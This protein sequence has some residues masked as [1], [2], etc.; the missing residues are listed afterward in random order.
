MPESEISS[1]T[2]KMLEAGTSRGGVAGMEQNPSIVAAREYKEGKLGKLP[3]DARFMRMVEAGRDASGKKKPADVTRRDLVKLTA[4][5]SFSA[6]LALGGYGFGVRFMFPN[7]LNEPEKRIR[8]AELDKFREMP[9]GGVNN[10]WKNSG[11]WIIRDGGTIAALSTTCTH[12]GCIPSWLEADRKFKCPC[13]GSGFDQRGVNFE[14]P[15]PRPLERFKVIDEDGILVVDK[16]KKYQ[17]E[18]GEW[19]NPES[20]IVV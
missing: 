10:E 18:K 14:G 9:R 12:L 20:Y 13:H 16:S 4:W 5:G 7:V 1:A 6:A 3:P 2:R 19:N 8:V 15:A 17:Q 11:F